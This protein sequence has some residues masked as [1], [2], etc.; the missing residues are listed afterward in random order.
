MLA[1][2]GEVVIFG[3]VNTLHG[4]RLSRSP[5]SRVSFD[6]R[7]IP[8]RCLPTSPQRSVNAGLSFTPG[9]YYDTEMVEP[10]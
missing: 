9:G 1:P 6:F 8:R 3:A 2:L 7:I 5:R 10:A 4:S